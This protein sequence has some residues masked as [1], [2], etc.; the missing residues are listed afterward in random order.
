M[1]DMGM[2]HYCSLIFMPCF[3]SL[4]TCRICRHR[5]KDEAMHRKF[6]STCQA[7][8]VQFDADNSCLVVLVCV[9]LSLVV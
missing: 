6:R 4:S 9:Q 8:L 2:G 3:A 5:C 7:A 1:S